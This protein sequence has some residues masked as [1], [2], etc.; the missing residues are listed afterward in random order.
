[1]IFLEQICVGLL[2]TYFYIKV[3]HVKIIIIIF[4][5]ER[6]NGFIIDLIIRRLKKTFM[7]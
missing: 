1:M 6:N 3:Q 4:Y 2:F 5:I 7:R